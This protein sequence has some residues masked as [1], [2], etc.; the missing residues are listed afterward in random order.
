M[1]F[2]ANSTSKLAADLRGELFE[3]FEAVLQEVVD[4]ASVEVQIIVHENVPQPGHW[5]EPL[6]KV[7]REESPL[8][9]QP[10]R[11]PVFLNGSQPLVGNNVIADI[12]DY[13][14]SQLKVSLDISDHKG[15]VDESGARLATQGSQQPDILA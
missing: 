1:P 15:I 14:D 3:V 9:E 13:L 8:T 6:S 10:D 11:I 12:K 7:N 4:F 5:H 2:V